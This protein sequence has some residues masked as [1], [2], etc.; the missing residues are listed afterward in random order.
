MSEIKDKGGRPSKFDSLSELDLKN[1]ERL[2]KRGFTDKEMSEFVDVTEQTFNNWKKDHPEFF[3]SLKDWKL[4]ADNKVERS[5][6]ERAT[7]YSHPED[8]IFRAAGEKEAL[9]VKTEKH[10]APDTTA[11]I[12]WLNNRKPNEYKNRFEYKGDVNQTNTDLTEDALD[13]R[14]AELSEKLKNE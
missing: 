8:K 12:Y 4:E 7:G 11:C 13:A 2:A 6:Y 14:I 1:I 3:E 5:L 10:Y 9:V